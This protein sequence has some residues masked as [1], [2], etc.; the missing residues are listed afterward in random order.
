[1]AVSVNAG[2]KSDAEHSSNKP[3]EGRKKTKRKRSIERR[4]NRD[5]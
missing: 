4:K 5:R 3:I 1:M 2:Y